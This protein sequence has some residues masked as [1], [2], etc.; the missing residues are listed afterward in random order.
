MKKSGR[1]L[2]SLIGVLFSFLGIFVLFQESPYYYSGNKYGADFYTDT[3]HAIAKVANNIMYLYDLLKYALGGFLILFGLLLIV[4]FVFSFKTN[5]APIN[6]KNKK[7]QSISNQNTIGKKEKNNKVVKAVAED[8][9]SNTMECPYCY[10]TVTVT[11]QEN[12]NGYKICPF[13]DEKLVFN[14]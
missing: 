4:L 11:Q 13:C 14:E 5:D 12:N 3:H 2:G 6:Q 9:E 8:V 10:K 7:V 1:L